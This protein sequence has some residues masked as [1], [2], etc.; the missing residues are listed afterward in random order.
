MC[1]TQ[2]ST[3]GGSISAQSS[4]EEC[5]EAMVEL[6][7]AELARNHALITL[8]K[9]VVTRTPK[10]TYRYIGYTKGTCNWF[11]TKYRFDCEILI[12]ANC[13]FF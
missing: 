10:P 12:I 1:W 3:G 13:E 11:F 9:C 5:P 7:G 4:Q 6:G 2:Y 8:D